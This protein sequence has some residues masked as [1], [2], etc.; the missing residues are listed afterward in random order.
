MVSLLP[1]GGGLLTFP[2]NQLVA[3][4][5]GAVGGVAAVIAIV[6]GAVYYRKIG[7]QSQRHPTNV[8]PKPIEPLF[9]PNTFS[10][11]STNPP[12]HRDTLRDWSPMGLLP[13]DTNVQTSEILPPTV[14]VKPDSQTATAQLPASSMAAGTSLLN[15]LPRSA[16]AVAA[17]TAITSS[18]GMYTRASDPTATPTR[19]LSGDVDSRPNDQAP[20]SS[21]SPGQ[22]SSS[23]QP[24]QPSEAEPE[25]VAQAFSTTNP[26]GSHLTDEQSELVQG[27]L[28]HNVPLPAVVVAI[29]GMLRDGRS[30]S[31]EGSGSQNNN[32][33]GYDFI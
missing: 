4:I 1:C 12:L 24:P 16:E 8:D 15:T 26:M 22:Y 21:V 18:P 19:P 32:P 30:G 9:Q 3:A 2:S 5:G 27:L 28:R 11:F 10:T 13:E 20:P 33:P 25:T 17:H 14:P 7:Y 6:L 31:G 29:E 23:R